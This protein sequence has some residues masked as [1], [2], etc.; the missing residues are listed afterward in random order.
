MTVRRVTAGVLAI[1][2]LAC[3]LFAAGYMERGEG[4]SRIRFKL[5]Q[6][7]SAVPPLPVK[8]VTVDPTAIKPLTPEQA[9]LEN[10]LVP[11][12]KG[13]VTPALPFVLPASASPLSPRSAVDCLTAAIYY[14]SAGQPLDGQ[15]AV[16]QVVLNR[17]RH[18]AY[19]KSVCGVVFQGAERTTGCQFTFTCDG[20]RARRPSPTGWDTA[21]KVA[22]AAL[23]GRVEPSVGTSTHYHTIFVVPYWA[24]SLQKIT[25]LGA[26]IFY[27]FP[28]FWGTRAAYSGAYAGESSDAAAEAIALGYEPVGQESKL[29]D[30]LGT[31]S[32]LAIAAP[33][34]VP[35]RSGTLDVADKP[36][37][38]ADESKGALLIDD[39]DRLVRS[40]QGP[41]ERTGRPIA[42]ATGP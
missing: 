33:V 6:V 4:P 41:G 2:V 35:L 37:L 36:V 42:A 15:R 27:R 20:S 13:V 18:P 5:A 40:V 28:G 11:G 7:R 12:L 8:L 34:L 25:T 26:H 23:A 9:V 31:T 19:P 29:Q 24:S 3:G 39:A 30:Q 38:R 21:R 10:R 32:G 22:Q 17:M 14:E 1:L 16:A